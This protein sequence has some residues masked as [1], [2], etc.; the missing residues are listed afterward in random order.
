MSRVPTSASEAG[1]QVSIG[2]IESG[3]E[4]TDLTPAGMGLGDLGIVGNGANGVNGLAA[5]LGIG[6]GGVKDQEEERRRKTENIVSTIGTRWG[7]VSPEG[8]ERAAK[9]VGLECLW[10][11]GRVRAKRT[12]SIA[13]N[14]LLVDVEFLGEEVQNVT[15]ELAASGSEVGK[16]APEGAELLKR[17][18]TGEEESY[19]FLD[20]FVSNLEKLTR[21]D[22]LTEGGV[23]CFDAVEGLRAALEKVFEWETAELREKREDQGNDVMLERHVLCR[24]S[25]RPQVHAKGRVGLAVQYW[26]DRRLLPPEGH[27]LGA[28]V[29]DTDNTSSENGLNIFSAVLECEASESS[30]YPSIRVS[31]SWVSESVKIGNVTYSNQLDIQESSISWQEPPPTLLKPPNDGSM[32]IDTQDSLLQGR[33]LNVRFVARFEP[34]VVVPLQTAID[35]HQSVG[36]PLS[37]ESIQSTT[38]ESL[39]FADATPSPAPQEQRTVTKTIRS[40]D[41]SGNSTEHRH[42]YALFP[43]QPDYG[44]AIDS[45]PFSHPRQIIEI[46]PILRQWALLGSL[47]RRSFVPDAAPETLSKVNDNADFEMD[48]ELDES[49]TVEEEL[50]ALLA[51]PSS[52]AENGTREAGDTALPIDITLAASSSTPAIGVVWPQAEELKSVNFGV[53]LNGMI[54]VYSADSEKEPERQRTKS[55]LEVAEDMGVMVAWMMRDSRDPIPANGTEG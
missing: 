18:L 35:I 7:Y 14:D 41:S 55:I 20:A 19:V 53:G 17:D 47:L 27:E 22:K 42:K 29:L 54:E 45:L 21:M 24:G 10:E 15:L 50:A 48:I 43:T 33:P 12:L 28:M 9:R 23:S 31:D 38:Y 16:R 5:G 32:D 8:V 40:Y 39:L 46:L 13:G 36:S 34:P 51:S 26:I 37:Q 25:G 30:L 4:K 2:A 52:F 1:T 3:G 11:K 44:R 6:M 49:M